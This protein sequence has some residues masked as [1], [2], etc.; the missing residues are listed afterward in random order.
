VPVAPA[1]ADLSLRE[2]AARVRA[3]EIAS[4]DLVRAALA[5]VDERDQRLGAVLTRADDALS[6][7][8][9]VDRQVAAGTDP[10][11]LAGVPVGLKDN[12]CT[13]GLRTT[14]GS[15]LLEHFRP[16]YDATV[17]TRL[18]AAG[19]IPILKLNCDEFAMGSSTENSAFRPTGNPWDLSRVPGGSSGGS[20]AAVAAGL[21]AG[22]LGTDT[23]GSIR[24]PASFCGVVGVKPSY[25]RVSRYGIIA[26]ASSL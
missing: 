26:Y 2:S 4:V 25:G 7:A 20:A 17:V 16:A 1:L 21:C 3:G 24:L 6:A 12:I 8:E 13:R 10:G 15:R 14:A 22:A 18:R 5:R 23:G 9:A 11:P 19:A